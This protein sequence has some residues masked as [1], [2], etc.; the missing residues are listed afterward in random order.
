MPEMRTPPFTSETAWR[1]RGNAGAALLHHTTLIAS[2]TTG[3][4]QRALTLPLR[5]RGIQSA[6]ICRRC[7]ATQAESIPSLNSEAPIA[8]QRPHRAQVTEVLS[9]RLP[10]N[11][12]TQ[13]LQHSRSEHLDP[14]EKAQRDSHIEK[15]KEIRGVV[16]SAGLMDKTV[17][18]RV[19]GRRW[20][21]KIGKVFETRQSLDVKTANSGCS[22]SKATPN[23][24]ST[25]RTTPLSSAT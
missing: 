23:T 5:T 19:P 16:V 25:T 10:H 1:L 20:N 7:L 17:R 9:R 12:P 18:V 2:T 8:S 11:I 6:W 3:M 4:S 13:Y 14:I 24:W 21:K 15:H 22:T